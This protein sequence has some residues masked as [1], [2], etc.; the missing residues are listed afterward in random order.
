MIE[1]LPN[2]NSYSGRTKQG[3]KELMWPA[4]RQFDM[5]GLYSEKH[6]M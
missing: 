2:E 6:L 1:F 4:G 3:N 5:P